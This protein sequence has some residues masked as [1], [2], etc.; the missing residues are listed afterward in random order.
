MAYIA[1]Y[2][3]SSPRI[4]KECLP[5]LLKSPPRASLSGFLIF[6]HTNAPLMRS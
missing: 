1:S 2:R 6:R 5:T 3:P 4:F